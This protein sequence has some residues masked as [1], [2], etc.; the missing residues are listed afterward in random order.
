MEKS[1]TKFVKLARGSVSST[2]LCARLITGNT[3]SFAKTAKVIYDTTFHMLNPSTTKCFYTWI[4][5]T[6]TDSN[7]DYKYIEL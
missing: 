4:E 7:K 1:H 6:W 5:K 3:F 2:A